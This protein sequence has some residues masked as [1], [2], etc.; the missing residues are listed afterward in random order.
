MEANPIDVHR[1]TDA[2]LAGIDILAAQ[3]PHLIFIAT[4]NFENAIDP[5]FIS[6]ADLV[7]YIGIPDKSTSEKIFRDTMITMGKQW[8]K[9]LKLLDKPEFKTLMNDLNGMD[10]RRI[11]KTVFSA[12]TF[13]KAVALDPNLLTIH[14][15]QKAIKLAKGK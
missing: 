12:C 1:A 9:M 15:I 4:S 5:A 6:R 11:R 10:G 13:D 3:Y 2:L 14:D 7:E 8:P